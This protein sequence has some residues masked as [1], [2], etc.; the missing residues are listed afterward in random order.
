MPSTNH[1]YVF[2]HLFTWEYWEL[3]YKVPHTG[4]FDV[5][6]G[7]CTFARDENDIESEYPGFSAAY[8]VLKDNGCDSMLITALLKYLISQEACEPLDAVLRQSNIVKQVAT[9]LA[10]DFDDK[11][12]V[13][14][15]SIHNGVTTG[16][17]LPTSLDIG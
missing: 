15:L 14:S 3:T 11:T 1:E 5:G 16:D 13:D 6:G 17:P 10:L 12:I 2:G 7:M 8:A 9:G 4:L